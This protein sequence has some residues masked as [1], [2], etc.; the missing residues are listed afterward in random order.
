MKLIITENQYVNLKKNLQEL[1]PK[2][3]GVKEF[4]KLVKDTPGLLRHLK[5]TSHKA[6][7]EYIL[8]AYIKDFDELRDEADEFFKKKQK[9]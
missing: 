2:S 7:E 5:F 6:L 3:S 4:L 1:S 8:D 9:K